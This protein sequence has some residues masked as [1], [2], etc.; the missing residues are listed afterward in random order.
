MREGRIEIME[1]GDPENCGGCR[2]MKAYLM[3]LSK[4]WDVSFSLIPFSFVR[5]NLTKNIQRIKKLCGGLPKSIPVVIIKNSRGLHM[6]SGDN[7][8][9]GMEEELSNY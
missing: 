8:F 7:G 4:K 9:E 5:P 2:Q 3:E 6:F 1:I